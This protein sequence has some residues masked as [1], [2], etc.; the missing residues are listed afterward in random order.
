MERDAFHAMT[1]PR[2]QAKPRPGIDIRFDRMGRLVG[3]E[4]MQRLASAHAAVLGLG[5]VGSYAAEALARS[6][7]GKLT[8]IDF[9]T[10]CVTNMNRQLHALNETIGE[11]KATLMADRVRS[12]NPAIQVVAPAEFY[13][14]STS[15]R[16]L[17]NPPDIL[18]DCIDN[19]TAKM[20][21]L[22][23]CLQRN[24]PVITA[25]G[26]AAKLDPTRIRVV[27]LTETYMDPL[28]KVI[29]KY[30]KSRY[31]LT[32]EDLSRVIA[33][34]SDEP[35]RMPHADYSSPVCGV[36]CVCPGGDNPHHSCQKRHV[37]HGSAVFVT[38]AFG[39]T[40]A[41]VAVRKLAGLPCEFNNRTHPGRH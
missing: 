30:T 11:H 13:D 7:V 37:I 1:T 29:R 36:D 20:H 8:L 23:Q 35:V 40:A 12:I 21:L 26:A 3:P 25:L 22:V 9:D 5:G 38:A 31:G 6:G 4:A 27:P 10:V 16:L 41:S 2:F 33:V 39:M 19:I 28:A 17:A 34:F 15:D 14:A 18:L 24:I 32:Q